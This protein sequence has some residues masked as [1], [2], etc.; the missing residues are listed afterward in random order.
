MVMR[1]LYEFEQILDRGAGF[2]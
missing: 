1:H 2:R